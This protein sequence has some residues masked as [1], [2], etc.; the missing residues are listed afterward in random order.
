MRPKKDL[1]GQRFGRLLVIE[2]AEDYVSKAGNRCSRWR[3]K[4]NCGNT[5]VY[6]TGSNLTTG[7]TRSCGC[8]NREVASKSHKKHNEYILD[9]R[10]SNGLYGVGYCTNTGSEFYFDV[11]DFDKI[12]HCNWIECITATNYRVLQSWDPKSRAIVRMHW[13]IVGKYA[14][15]ADRTGNPLSQHP[16]S[17]V[18]LLPA[19][20]V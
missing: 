7:N 8:L 4:C 15:H 12:K 16:G 9:L 19:L 1:V 18:C 6:T 11:E 2:R 14:D 20:W 13:L 10:D 3:C 17:G 5:L